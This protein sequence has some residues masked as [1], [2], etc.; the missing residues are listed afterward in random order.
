MASKKELNQL[1]WLIKQ[2]LKVQF[3]QSAT[4]KE[5]NRLLRL[6]NEVQLNHKARNSH[7]MWLMN[8]KFQKFNSLK[9]L[10]WINEIT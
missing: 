3:D 9:C 4:V 5:S 6:M 1:T 8:Q 2:T 10:F 7:L